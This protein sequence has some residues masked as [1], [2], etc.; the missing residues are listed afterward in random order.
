MGLLRHST[1]KGLLIELHAGHPNMGPDSFGEVV[2]FVCYFFYLFDGKCDYA[3]RQSTILTTSLRTFHARA[4]FR[5]EMLGRST[6]ELNSDDTCE[7]T[8][9]QSSI[10]TK[11]LR[12]LHQGSVFL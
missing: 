10:S 11:N 7:D 12:M 3:P 6:P 5:V 9:R 4:R 8:P 2:V 1:G